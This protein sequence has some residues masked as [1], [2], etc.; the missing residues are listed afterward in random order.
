MPARFPPFFL[1]FSFKKGF[2]FP[3]YISSYFSSISEIP[4]PEKARHPLPTLNFSSTGARLKPQ[5]EI[6]RRIRYLSPDQRRKIHPFSTQQPLDLLKL[7]KITKH[8]ILNINSY[9]KS[10]ELPQRRAASKSFSYH[11]QSNFSRISRRISNNIHQSSGSGLYNESQKKR[12][13]KEDGKKK[14]RV[15][16][17]QITLK[18][19]LLLTLVALTLPL[20]Q[21]MGFFIYGSLSR[22]TPFQFLKLLFLLLTPYKI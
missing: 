7:N 22:K 17:L 9:R 13:E 20:R 18:L 15:S 6:F 5:N 19:K 3:N 12:N 8:Q 2:F 10:S 16:P 4:I 14:P 11:L 1:L 21:R